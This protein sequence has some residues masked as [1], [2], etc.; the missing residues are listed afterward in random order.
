MNLIIIPISAPT[1]DYED[2][3]IEELYEEIE[4]TI[5]KV[6]NKFLII[7][8]VYWNSVVGVLYDN[9]NNVER[10]ICISKI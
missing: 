8:Q 7:I 10:Q 9:W 6:H 2:E 4:V 3:A 1:S 5:A